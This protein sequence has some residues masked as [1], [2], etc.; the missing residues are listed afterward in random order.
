MILVLMALKKVLGCVVLNFINTPCNYDYI[1]AIIIIRSVKYR[2][3][4]VNFHIFNTSLNTH[5]LG[6]KSSVCVINLHP[7]HYSNVLYSDNSVS[8]L[9][10]VLHFCLLNR[11]SCPWNFIHELLFICELFS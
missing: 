11:I 4:R 7:T 3:V 5:S 9:S 1:A 6:T 8:K 10:T 2:F